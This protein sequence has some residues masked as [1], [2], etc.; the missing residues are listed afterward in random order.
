MKKRQQLEQDMAALFAA[1]AKFLIVDTETTGLPWKD[2]TA[3]IVE[4]ACV[5]QDGKIAYQSLIKPD[6]PVPAK[7]TKIHGL[8]DADLALSPTFVEAWPD[9]LAVLSQYEVIYCYNSAFDHSMILATAQ[10][11]GIAVPA[12]IAEA[13]WVC[14]MN[15]YA[16]YHGA[17]DSYHQSYTFQKLSVA[18][19]RLHA[20]LSEIHRATGDC[21][22]TLSLMRA[23]A[24]RG[25]TV[26]ASS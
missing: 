17:W 19:T 26:T 15:R 16:E 6:V 10:R 14:M 4:I 20:P 23:L 22:N 2:R 9:L 13:R 25:A 1:G 18:C 11:F 8:T 7:A 5:N 12:Q 21:Q 3:Q 24:A